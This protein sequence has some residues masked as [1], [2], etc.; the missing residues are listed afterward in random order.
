MASLVPDPSPLD[1]ATSHLA[2]GDAPLHVAVR[3]AFNPNL[4][5][6][7][8]PRRA[9][10]VAMHGHG[11][12]RSMLLT[13]LALV[14][15]SAWLAPAASD[16]P[17]ATLVSLGCSQ[18]NAT[19]A[20][21][22]LA[23]LN[24]TFAALRATYPPRAPPPASAGSP[25]PRSRAPP[26]RRSPWRSAGRTSPAETASPASMRRPR[27]FAACAAPP[28]AAASYSRWLR[29]PLRE[30]GLLRPGHAPGQHADLQRPRRGRH[31]RRLRGYGAG[32][33]RRPRGRRPSCAGARRRDRERRHVRGGA[34]RGDGPGGRLRAV[35]EGGVGEHRRLPA[36]YRRPR[37]GRWLLH[38][39]LQLALLPGECNRG[40][41]RVLALWEEI[42]SERSHHRRHYGGVACFLL[43]IGLLTF[44]L[45]R[46]SRKLR[47]KRG[48]RRGTLNWK[49]RFN[50][51]VGM[52][53][54]LAYLHQ[55]FHVCIIHRDIKSSNV[56][57]DDDFQPKIADFGLARL[58]P[59]DHSH[60]ST[61]FAGTLGYTAPECAIHGQLSEKVDTCSF[62]VV[63]LEIL[64]GRKSND[65][66]LDPETQYL[67][68]WA[69]KLYESEN[70]L[71]LVDESLDREEYKPDEVKRIMEIALLYTQSAVAARPT[72]PEVRGETSTSSSSSGS[73]AT[74]SVSQVSG[75]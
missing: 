55:E 33:G 73:K 43:L 31:R 18:Y 13:A 26:P 8:T 65:T 64:S 15:A 66:R 70:L 42:K 29:D 21:A 12:T 22:F 59:D 45:I 5:V 4:D 53:R 25:R 60:L 75:R 62:G 41:C 10:L 36:Q 30:R 74:I 32:A 38:E 1:A 20:S 67:L 39:I 63:V 68:E 17:Q 19:P 56:L 48:E 3:P 58:L 54:G 35:P 6:G 16:D 44:L 27:A 51:I 11:M 7:V 40:P 57:L 24:S 2:A 47:P 71:A 69:W 72:M 46:R 61:K 14:V 34:V 50:I 52:A 9:P 37:R 23:V 49:Q 28:T